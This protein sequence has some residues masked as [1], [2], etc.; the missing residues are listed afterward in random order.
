MVP[1]LGKSLFVVRLVE[2]ESSRRSASMQCRMNAQ[3]KL[4]VLDSLSEAGRPSNEDAV[5]ATPAAA[6]VIDGTK[7]P[8]DHTLT[9]GPSDA[10]WHAQALSSALF[11][12][13]AELTVDPPLSLARA[14]ELL[15]DIYKRNA[16]PAPTHEQPS[17]CLALVALSASAKLHLF[18]IG[19]CRIVIERA[20]KVCTFGTS[21][22]ERLET[23]AI[24]ELVRLRDT[25]GVADPRPQLCSMLRRNFETAMNKPGGY[26][27]VHPSLPWLH[28]VEHAEL[29]IRDVDHV[30]IASDGFYRLVNVFGAYDAAELISSALRGGALAPLCAEL[31]NREAGDPAC[32]RY[33]RLK[34]MDDASAVLIRICR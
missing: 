17:A 30:L 2:L 25:L 19:D 11:A 1:V 20:G 28:A 23:A 34:S 13:Y 31:R 10:T 12:Q 32:R 4:D 9:S 21:G 7:G 29:S 8:F 6:W 22:I 27:V 5:G 24:A 14:A 16:G 26:W 33:P 15:S 18:N 3:L